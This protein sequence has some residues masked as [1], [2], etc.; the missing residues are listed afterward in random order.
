MPNLKTLSK[1]RPALFEYSG[2]VKNGTIITFGTSNTKKEIEAS[3]YKNLLEHFCGRTVMAGTSQIIRNL[4]FKLNNALKGSVGYWLYN[5]T[6]GPKLKGPI[7][8]SY[9]CSIL[10][11]EGFCEAFIVGNKIMIRFFSDIKIKI[12][13][14]Q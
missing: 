7:V 2:Q 3:L 13:G 6:N 8:T 11:H 9:V 5:G 10:A 12:N 4:D 1:S 14:W